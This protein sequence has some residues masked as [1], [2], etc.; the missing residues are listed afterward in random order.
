MVTSYVQLLAHRYQKQL[1]AEAQE[2]I[3]FAVE[4]AQRMKALIDGLLAYLGVETQEQEFGSVAC[5]AVL[6]TVLTTLQPAITESQA[7][8]THDRLPTVRGNQRQ[9]GYVLHQLLSN[10]LT[11]H[12]TAPAL[13][14]VWATPG[15]QEWMCRP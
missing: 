12:G 8:L 14:H 9:I 5:E 1:D 11:F 4:G 13:V 3:G 10:A 6:A 15:E 2:F 7:V